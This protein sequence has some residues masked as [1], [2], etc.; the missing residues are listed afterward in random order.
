MEFS[1]LP[2]QNAI[3]R[4]VSLDWQRGIGRFVLSPVGEGFLYE[5]W[6]N[7]VTEM[8]LPRRQSAGAAAA[9]HYAREPEHGRFEL[10]MLS[11]EV[12]EVRAASW[13]YTKVPV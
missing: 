1:Q 13:R 3:L 4:G 2:L 5:L 6:F 12:L 10:A 11:G 7:D 9:V 8:T